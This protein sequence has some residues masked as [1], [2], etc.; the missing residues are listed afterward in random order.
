[1]GK[2]PI[3]GLDGPGAKLFAKLMGSYPLKV[4]EIGGDRNAASQ[5]AK[6]N[7]AHH[8]IFGLRVHP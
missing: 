6:K 5:L 7:P 1:M 3:Q 8:C 2:R 4:V